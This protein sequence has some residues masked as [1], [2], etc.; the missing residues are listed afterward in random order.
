MQPPR[1]GLDPRL[2]RSARNVNSTWWH[3]AVNALAASPA[4]SRKNRSRI[5]RT[6]GIQVGSA[7]IES[8]CFFFS[9]QVELGDWS[10]INH[11]CYFDSRDRI[12]VGER[13]RVAMEVMLCT[14]GHELGTE[15]KRAGDYTSA[16]IAVGDGAWLGTRT[17]VLPGVTIGAGCVVAAGAVV[18]EDL[19]PHGLYAG[20]PA[21]R[22][23]DLPAG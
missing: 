21:R 8:G 15:T 17:L 19:E 12:V 23:R 22:I 9:D 13:V 11:R 10:L 6:A 2:F 7:L 18:A 14:S 4:V 20:V 1:R 16:P 3:W 5:L